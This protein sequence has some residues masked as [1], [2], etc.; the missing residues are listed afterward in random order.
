MIRHTLRLLWNKKRS[1]FLLFLEIFFAFAIL[2]AVFTI[3]TRFVRQYNTPIGFETEQVWVAHFNF[4]NMDNAQDTVAMLDM[5]RR[6]KQEVKAMPE[7]QQASFAGFVTPLSGGTWQTV[8]DDNGF[9]LMTTLHWADEDYMEVAQLKLVQ[10]RWFQEGDDQ[11][12]YKPVVISKKLYD[13]YFQERNIE[14][15]IYTIQGENKIIGVVENYKYRGDFSEEDPATFLYSPAASMESS[16]LLVRIAPN[17]PPAFEEELN[18]AIA[19]ITKTRDFTIEHLETTRSIQARQVWIPLVSLLS[20]CGFLV[21]NVAM[22]LFGV[23]WYNIS[24]R[25]AEIGLRRTLGASRGEISLQF[26]GEIMLVSASAL[27]LGLV[28]A[29]QLPLMGVMAAEVA[30]TDYYVAMAAAIALITALVLLCTFYPS[31]QASRIQPA[32]ALHE[33]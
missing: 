18:Q 11:G 9:E 1:N 23:L 7:V 13:E 32:I 21:L 15:S 19:N 17:T 26:I 10:G 20:V 4:D 24:K 29:V 6:L 14:D 31:Q 22:G 16:N 3:V 8:N 30:S 5:K 28:F 2:F 33:E 12:R 25:R 27:L